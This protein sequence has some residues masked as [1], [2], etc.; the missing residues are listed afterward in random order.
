[1]PERP[2]G[3]EGAIIPSGA[4]ISRAED[5]AS[6]APGRDQ[7]RSLSTSLLAPIQGIMPRSFLPTSSI[8]SASLLRRIA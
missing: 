8:G 6:A 1:M 5:E 7:F 4:R 3:P 2:R